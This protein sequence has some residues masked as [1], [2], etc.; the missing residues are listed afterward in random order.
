MLQKIAE[1]R[2]KYGRA[3]CGGYG[4]VFQGVTFYGNFSTL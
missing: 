1:N 3:W 4:G 2:K